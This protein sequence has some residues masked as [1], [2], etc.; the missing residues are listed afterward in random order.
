M[1]KLLLLRVLG[2]G[3]LALGVVTGAA[4]NVH[5]NTINIPN[6][7]INATAN[8]DVTN[9]APNQSVPI[10]VT[11]QNVFLVDPNTAPPAD[12]T[13]DAGYLQIYLDD[14]N[15]T[16]LLITAQATFNVTI[17]PATP[18]GGHKLICRVYKHD[19]TPTSTEVNVDITVTATAGA[20]GG[21]DVVVSVDANTTTDTTTADT[22]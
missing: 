14:V 18:P 9:V 22:Y 2:L 11:V 12:H 7:S 20:D 8:T 3:S 21:V 19:G 15:T 1:K 5:D 16:P 4:C 13:T 10:T 17:P 6:A